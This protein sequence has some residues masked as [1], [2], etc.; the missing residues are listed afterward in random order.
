M[1]KFTPGDSVFHI[2]SQPENNCKISLTTLTTLSLSGLGIIIDID[3]TAYEAV[4][5]EHRYWNVL[6]NETI[7][8]WREDFI[9]LAS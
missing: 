6:V 7:S 8:Q 5:T 4:D 2:W 3:D 1:N 9:T